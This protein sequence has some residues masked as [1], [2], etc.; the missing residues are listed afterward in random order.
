MEDWKLERHAF[1]ISQSVCAMI[2]AKGMEA[3][4]KQR[5]HLGHSMAYTD[6]DFIDLQE[7]YCIGHN[8]VLAYMQ[9]P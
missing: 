6:E 4:N 1:I 3:E 5:E 7:K 2:E 9:Q 8:Q